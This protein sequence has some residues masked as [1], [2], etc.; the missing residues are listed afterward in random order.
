MRSTQKL[1]HHT[2]TL[3]GVRL[4]Y[5]RAGAGDLVLLLHG[6]GQTWWEWRHIIPPLAERFTVVAPDLRGLGDS[7]RP[8]AGYDKK[9]IAGDIHRLVRHLGFERAFVVGHDFG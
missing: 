5:V 6:W 9:T 4:H 7:G 8:S 2:V 1:A 3:D